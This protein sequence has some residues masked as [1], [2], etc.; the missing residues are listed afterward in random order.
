MSELRVG[1]VAA[2]AG[3]LRGEIGRGPEDLPFPRLGQPSLGRCGLAHLPL[4]QPEVRHVRLAGRVHHDVVRLQVAV[5]DPVLMGM[6][7][8]VG[9]LVAQ[10]GGFPERQPVALEPAMEREAVDVLVDDVQV[11]AVA[12]DRLHARQAR[13]VE[14]GRGLGLADEAIRLLLRRAAIDRDFHGHDLVEL[15]IPGLPH[16]P[17]GPL[18]Q[19]LQEDVVGDPAADSVG[20]CPDGDRTARRRSSGRSRG[21]KQGT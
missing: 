13:V 9:H 12:A 14:L 20:R 7:D 15:G 3:L 2:A 10:R 17:E 11:L 18:A 19:V 16:R 6:V 8:R 5:D 4:G 21:H 1:L